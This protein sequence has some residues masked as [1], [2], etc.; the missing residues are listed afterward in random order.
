[1]SPLLLYLLLLK[2]T[3][4][5]FSGMT[6]LPIIRQDLVVHYRVLTDRQLNAAVAVSRTGPGPYGL[7]VAS[8]GYFVAGAPGATA[9]CAALMTPPFLIVLLLRYAR[10]RA[11]NPRVRGAIQ[12]VTIAASGLLINITVPLARDAITGPLTAAIAMATVL[13]LVLTRRSTAW[14]IAASALIGLAGAL[15]GLP[16]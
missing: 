9:G 8:V 1:V 2:A 13:F 14:A 15:L 3:V 7:Y 4:T 10:A 6:S 11:E 5:S 16:A 12:A